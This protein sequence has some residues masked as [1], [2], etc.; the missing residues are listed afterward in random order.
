VIIP[1]AMISP[2][3]SARREAKVTQFAGAISPSAR[4]N[5]E[6]MVTA[7]ICGRW[8]R[9]DRVMLMLPVVCDGVRTVIRPC[10]QRRR[11][12]QIFG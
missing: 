1:G 2:A 12:I 5:V 11:T 6:T 3:T 4:A 10:F 8:R 7:A 9:I